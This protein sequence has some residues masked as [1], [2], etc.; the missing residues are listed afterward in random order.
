MWFYEPWGYGA[1]Y[2]VSYAYFAPAWRPASLG[3]RPWRH[4]WGW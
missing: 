3:W 2:P 1:A 4:A